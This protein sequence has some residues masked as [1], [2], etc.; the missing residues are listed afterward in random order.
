MSEAAKKTGGKTYEFPLQKIA[1]VRNLA[2]FTKYSQNSPVSILIKEIDHATKEAL[3]AFLKNLE[4]PGINISY[5]LSCGNEQALLSTVISRCEVIRFGRN[6]DQADY[7]T[8]TDL[9]KMS[10]GQK[11]KS[12]EMIKKKEDAVYYLQKI[13]L[14]AHKKMVNKNENIQNEAL[15]IKTAQKAIANLNSNAN[16][17]LQMTQFAMETGKL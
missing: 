8:V 14:G 9:I 17:N 15:I 6:S 1:D 7:E 5:F 4:E 3:N 11:I 2:D 10:F 13:V 12:F 16:L